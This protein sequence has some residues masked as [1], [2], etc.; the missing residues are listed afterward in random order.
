MRAVDGAEARGDGDGTDAHRVGTF[1][2][3][4]VQGT[5]RQ[6]QSIG[7]WDAAGNDG[8]IAVVE[9]QSGVGHANRSGGGG[10]RAAVTQ[11][12][13]AAEDGGGTRVGVDA[14]KGG[15]TQ[16][17]LDQGDGK[18]RTGA[19]DVASIGGCA[20]ADG[21]QGGSA[22]AGDDVASLACQSVH[23]AE[24]A[25]GLTVAIEVKEAA[26]TIHAQIKNGRHRGRWV[27]QD[28]VAAHRAAK[29]E[30][31]AIDDRAVGAC[32]TGVVLLGVKDEGAAVRL[33]DAGGGVEDAAVQGQAVAA[34]D[35]E[36]HR[37]GAAGQ[38]CRCPEDAAQS[39]QTAGVQ[40]DGQQAT[41]SVAAGAAAGA[42]EQVGE[43]VRAAGEEGQT[44]R[45][46]VVTQ[47]IFHGGGGGTEADVGGRA[48]D[49]KRGGG[50]QQFRGLV[51]STDDFVGRVENGE[52][53]AGA[54]GGSIG[55]DVRTHRHGGRAIG[56]ATLSTRNVEGRQ[57]N[58]DGAVA[59]SHT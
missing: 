28:G 12:E 42:A 44:V 45:S 11:D 55:N 40:A 3:Q 17:F 58:T 49:G 46:D 4:V 36:V 56:T 47:R 7:C 21:G 38:R 48:G 5:A 29:L 34:S 26:N 35:V 50:T 27:H 2:G 41:G 23:T 52:A 30:S 59:R 53:G 1:A 39:Q 37:G 57:R 43:A 22:R 32:G 19:A 14:G 8:Q 10:Q 6:G 13:A 25:D 24:L 18:I 31:A 16:A 20:G 15:G 33:D 51:Q 54:A 9:S